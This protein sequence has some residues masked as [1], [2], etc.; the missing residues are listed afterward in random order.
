[1]V[2]GAETV[3]LMNYLSF[4]LS[5]LLATNIFRITGVVWEAGAMCAY[6]APVFEGFPLRH[7]VTVSPL[8]GEALSDVFRRQLSKVGYSFTTSVERDLLDSIKVSAE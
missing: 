3:T 8:T 6:A 1:M 5:Q 2:N 4:M 7:A